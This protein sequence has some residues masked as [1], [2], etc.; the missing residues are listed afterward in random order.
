MVVLLFSRK[1]E[2]AGRFSYK[3]ILGSIVSRIMDSQNVH[4]LIFGTCKWVTKLR[5]VKVVHQLPL[6][7]RQFPEMEAMSRQAATTTSSESAIIANT[8]IV[9]RIARHHAN[10]FNY[11]NSFNPQSNARR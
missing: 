2:R 1:K 6:K 5:G 3:L 9:L 11:I 7:W 8:Y 10:C 4:V